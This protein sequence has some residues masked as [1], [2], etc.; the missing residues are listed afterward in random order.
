MKKSLAHCVWKVT[1]ARGA[2]R[3]GFGFYSGMN[4]TLPLT[5][6]LN[7]LI[8][9]SSVSIISLREYDRIIFS[10]ARLLVVSL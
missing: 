7:F 10:T 2:T 9:L 8:F 6:Y 5:F 4:A 1:M 3:L